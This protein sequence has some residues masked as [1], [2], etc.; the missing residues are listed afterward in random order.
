MWKTC[1]ENNYEYRYWQIYIVYW[2]KKK[3]AYENLKDI[4]AR[5]T[6][7]QLD[8]WS[9]NIVQAAH[10]LRKLPSHQGQMPTKYLAEDDNRPPFR[11]SSLENEIA[12][13]SPQ[14]RDLYG[15]WWWFSHQVARSCPTLA[16]SWTVACQAPCSWDSPGRNTGVGCHFVLQEIFLTQGSKPSLLHSRWILHQL[17]YLGSPSFCP[18]VIKN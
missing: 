16:S 2:I 7:S 15:V 17:S 10:E 6:Q 14:G 8:L 1:F 18:E 9:S 3:E 4:W 11:E 13:C 12:F 5:G